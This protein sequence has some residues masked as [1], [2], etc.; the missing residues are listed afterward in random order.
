MIL[1]LRGFRFQAVDTTAKI[2]GAA[3]PFGVKI[4]YGE[5]ERYQFCLYGFKFLFNGRVKNVRSE[6]P[7]I[8]REGLKTRRGEPTPP[9][10]CVTFHQQ[11]IVPPHAHH[12]KLTFGERE[13]QTRRTVATDPLGAKKFGG[14]GGDSLDRPQ[15]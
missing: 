14:T 13:G 1:S 4:G 12:S 7:R 9:D 8:F 10:S 15:P 11:R 6:S 2:G 3:T 5:Y